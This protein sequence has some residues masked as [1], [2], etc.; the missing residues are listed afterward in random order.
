MIMQYRLSQ[1]L[2]TFGSKN[3]VMKGTLLTLIVCLAAPAVVAQQDPLYAQYINNPF[4][5]NPAYAGLNTSL[6][7]AA[8]YR[9][10]WSGYEGSPTTLNA[11]G[12]ISLRQ[13][14]MGTG[15]MLVSDRIGATVT[16]EVYGSCAYRIPIGERKTLSFGLQAGFIHFKT[17]NSK[18][19][20]HDPGD[21]LFTEET[22]DTKPGLGAGLIATSDRYFIGLSMPRM[23][24]ATTRYG[25]AE[26]TAYT[27]H[28][29]AMGSYIFF[30]SERVRFRPSVLAKIA[31][32]APAS[33]DVNTAF[34][35]H[36]NYTAGVLTRNLSTYGL[37]LQALI[38]GSLRVAYALEVPTNRS[39]GSQFTTHEITVGLR[40]QVFQFHK[41]SVTSF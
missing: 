31:G 4:V 29:Y 40:A 36:E 41:Y 20:I 8:G 7:V 6:N 15:L 5:L 1:K 19:V 25:G 21:P 28:F 11:N 13:N 39:V 3:P 34:I 26:L 22:T 24:E 33:F 27:R 10:Q 35:F 2:L 23:L 18:L 9:Q 30:L 16:N 12:H 38:K 37:F 32:G 14:T 17:S